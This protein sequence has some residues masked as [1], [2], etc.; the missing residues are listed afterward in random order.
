V[1]DWQKQPELAS[2]V[3]SQTKDINQGKMTMPKG[4]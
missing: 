2:I 3:E 1:P 4:V